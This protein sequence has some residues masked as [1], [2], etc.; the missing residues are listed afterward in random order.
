MKTQWIEITLL[1]DVIFSREAATEGCHETLDFIPGSALF[2]AL[3]GRLASKGLKIPDVLQ[4]GQ[5]RVGNG[6]PVVDGETAFPV[7]FSFHREKGADR[8]AS[9]VNGLDFGDTDPADCTQV[10]SGYLAPTK[11]IQHEPTKAYRMKTAR[12]RGEY[13]TA[14]KNSLFGYESLTAGQIFRAAVSA[15]EALFTHCLP[16]EGHTLRLRLG[17]SRSAEYATVEI[18]RCE[19]VFPPESVTASNGTIALY[20]AS[21]FCPSLPDGRPTLDPVAA[22][23]PHLG[24]RCTL[25]TTHSYLRTRFY[26][27]WNRF[28]GGPDR[29]RTVLSAGS[30]LVFKGADIPEHGPLRTGLFQSEGLGELWVNPSWVMRPPDPVTSYTA[31]TRAEDKNRDGPDVPNVPLFILLRDRLGQDC[32]EEQA[33][34]LGK[35]WAKDWSKKIR[36]LQNAKQ[37]WPK[38]TQWSTIR[39]FASL[40]DGNCDQ[41]RS[42][43]GQPMDQLQQHLQ[44]HF[45][46]GLRRRVWD[47]SENGIATDLLRKLADTENGPEP[48]RIRALYH[49]SVAVYRSLSNSRNR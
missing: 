38:R 44:S 5:L 13:G 15:E 17:R 31:G 7:P 6:Y 49:A 42:D 36:S 46:D 40:P 34:Q 27:P 35:E 18:R 28:F 1:D 22:L 43:P 23:R 9:F 16:S 32:E 10:R 4:A 25:D 41:R 21:D 48:R 19:P 45:S 2:G 26:W 33:I 30:V 37:P 12:N 39:S 29:G 8:S 11:G 24:E 14:L 47:T 3:L 20:C